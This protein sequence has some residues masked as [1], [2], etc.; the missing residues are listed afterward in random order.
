MDS[1]HADPPSRSRCLPAELGWAW[2][3]LEQT[4]GQVT[5]AALARTVGWSERHFTKRFRAFFGAR[6]KAAARRLRF[7]HAFN[8]VASRP[9][10]DLAAIAAEAGFSDQS[11]MTREFEVFAGVAPGVLRAAHFDD[12]PGIPASVLTNR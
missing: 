12:L 10:S 5:I 2:D 9:R 7:A 6:P 3:V 1:W 4:H 8:L 11:H